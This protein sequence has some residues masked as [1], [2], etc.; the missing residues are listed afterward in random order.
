MSRKIPTRQRGM[1][2]IE[3]MIAMVIGL[4]ILAGVVN[5]FVASRHSARFTDGLQSMQENGRQ[6]IFVLQYAIRQ[7]GYS[8]SNDLTAIDLAT[9]N[10]DRITV[11][12]QSPV[13]CTGADTSTAPVPGVAVDEYYH[14]QSNNQVLCK[15]NVGTAPMPVAENI[16]AIRFLYGLD[17][18][19]DGDI[20]RYVRYTEVADVSQV[21]GIQFAILVVTDDPVKDRKLNK[22]FTILD[23]TKSSNDLFGR[24]VFQSTVIIRNRNS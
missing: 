19:D 6:A 22:T 8:E 4:I 15:G 21:A 20:E 12:H 9:S 1:S 23:D 10:A 13:D 2:L 11:R 17:T 18:D 24:Q 3:L 5:I 16:E 7:A 14:D